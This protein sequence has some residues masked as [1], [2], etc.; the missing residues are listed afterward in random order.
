L[1]TQER[2]IEQAVRAN[3]HWYHTMEVAPGVVTPGWFDLRP[4]VDR[5][6][7]PDVRGK[8]CLD[9]GT[10]DGF[11]AF[12]LERRGASEVV[13]TDVSD[14]TK[15][16]W[17]PQAREYGPDYLAKVAGPEKGAGFRIA[18]EALGSSVERMPV[19]IY[20][21]SPETVGTFDVIV[22]G[23]LLLH[24]RDP[25]GALEAVRS[26]CRGQFLSAETVR[27]GLSI[28]NPR[29]AVADLNGVSLGQWWVPTIAGHRKMLYAAGFA[30]ERSS[31]P[32]CIPHGSEHPPADRSSRARAQALLNRVVTGND[33]VPHVAVLTRPRL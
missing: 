11:L 13:A 21:L 6:P 27:L 10:Y 14:H 32:Y 19:S 12:E 7:W 3:P 2:D 20:D 30:I 9:V 4:I 8:R 33:G 23:S 1:A 22:C 29:R 17:P 5:M 31:R 15:W 16:D 26:V 18:K 24:L 28:R 25:L